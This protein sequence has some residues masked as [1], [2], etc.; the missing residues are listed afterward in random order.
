MKAR[1]LM[2]DA[3]EIATLFDRCFSS[4]YDVDAYDL[5]Y[6]HGLAERDRITELLYEGKTRSVSQKGAAK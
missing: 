1:E 3:P 5:F 6:V 4:E 2:K